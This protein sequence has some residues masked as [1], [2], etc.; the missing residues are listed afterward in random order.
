MHFHISYMYQLTLVKLLYLPVYNVFFPLN[1]DPNFN[2]H[3]LNDYTQLN[4]VIT[5]IKHS[6]VYLSFTG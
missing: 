2:Y 1:L 4:T 3:V 5:G 6:G